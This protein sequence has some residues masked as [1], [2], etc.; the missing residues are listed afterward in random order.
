MLLDWFFPIGF[1]KVPLA[2]S[3]AFLK[4]LIKNGWFFFFRFLLL[5]YEK[6]YERHHE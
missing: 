5:F 6:F 2:H 3:A 4:N 1:S